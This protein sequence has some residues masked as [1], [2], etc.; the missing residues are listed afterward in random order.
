MELLPPLITTRSLLGNCI[1]AAELGYL[2]QDTIILLLA[3]RLRARDIAQR[4][5][6]RRVRSSL[7]KEINWRV[8]GWHHLGLSAGLGWLQVYVARREGEG[9]FGYFDVD[10]Y[11]RFVSWPLV[12]WG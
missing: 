5:T 9:D 7:A 4:D 2:L 12:F 10:A 3:A 1:T 6:D 11:E 8:L